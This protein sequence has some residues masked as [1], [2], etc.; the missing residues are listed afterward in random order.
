MKF[1]HKVLHQYSYAFWWWIW[2][3]LYLTQVI[4]KKYLRV[5]I[6]LIVKQKNSSL[7]YLVHLGQIPYQGN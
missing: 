2:K 1:S 3:I 4:K 7:E 6:L 5:K